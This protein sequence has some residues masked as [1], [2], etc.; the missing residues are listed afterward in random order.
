MM[1][2]DGTCRGNQDCH[3]LAFTRASWVPPDLPTPSRAVCRSCTRGIIARLVREGNKFAARFVGSK[4][5]VGSRP[6]YD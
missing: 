2:H 5:Q 1:T 6:M 4:E 3:Q